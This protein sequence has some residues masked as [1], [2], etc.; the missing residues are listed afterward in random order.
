[1]DGSFEGDLDAWLEFAD[2]E[3]GSPR[4]RRR[5]LEP[6]DWVVIGLVAATL[7]G[8]VVLWP[9]GSA[10]QSAALQTLG[11]PSELYPAEIVASGGAP[12]AGIEDL[13]CI[14]VEFRIDGGPDAGEIYRQ[15][16]PPSAVNPEFT[17]GLTAILSRLTPNGRVVAVGEA[18]CA[19]EAGATCR[20]LT[21]EVTVDGL[22]VEADYLTSPD[23]PAALLR[24][25][26]EAIVQIFSGDGVVEALGV[27][28]TDVQVAYQ[29]TGDFQRR[30][31]L[32][33]T[34]VLFA[35]A[36]V[37]VG[38]WRGLAALGGVVTSLAVLLLFVVPA[39][40][41]GGSPMLIAMVGATAIAILTLYLSHGFA[42]MTHVA[43]LGIVGALLVTGM[44]AYIAT[45]LAYFSGFAT[46]ESTFLTLFE[47]ID[48]AGLLL[49]GI[50]LGTAGAL[51][52][53]AV[54]QAAA[55]WELAA[56]DPG[57]DRSMLFSRAMRIGRSHIAST[58][59]TLLLAYAGAALPL[60]IL[61][62]LS[63]QSLGAI[64]NS[65]IVAVEIVRTLVG[66]IG[67]V[68]AVPLTTWL[69]ARTAGGAPPHPH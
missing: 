64:A 15:S 18:P 49:A 41:E 2:D 60:L 35:V 32:L 31:V 50:V 47:G 34:T 21:V 61:F 44:L 1:M 14:D 51:D 67:L 62:V 46:E 23:D 69:A 10:R 16:F 30:G 6:L 13:T 58:V 68:A 53:V 27:S 25:R 42:P 11:V 57:S 20:V 17:V 63:E 43:L 38:L 52:D 37:A 56:A 54:T 22:P 12:C 66:S 48:V 5:R 29:F 40:L 19:F 7:L 55:V 65:E 3:L 33:W 9:T 45:E 26:D 8:L 4:P 39:L 59:N 36:V 24:V 28:P